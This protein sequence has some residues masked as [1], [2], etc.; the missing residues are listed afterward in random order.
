MISRTG[1]YAAGAA[2]S[3]TS[4]VRRAPVTAIQV[5]RTTV[6]GRQPFRMAVSTSGEDTACPA[7]V[8][9]PITAPDGPASG[10]PGPTAIGMLKAAASETTPRTPVKATTKV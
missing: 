6:P 1:R 10:P 8:S 5:T 7:A 3:R 4:D 9:T 2:V